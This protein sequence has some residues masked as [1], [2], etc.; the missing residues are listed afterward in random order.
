MTEREKAKTSESHPI[1][2]DFVPREALGDR[3]RLGMTFCSGKKASGIDGLWER[4]LDADL[5]RMREEDNVAVLV[6]LSG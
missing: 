4:D 6:S 3:G 1:R 2:V 5:M